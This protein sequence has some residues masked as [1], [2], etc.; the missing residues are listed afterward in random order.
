MKE[1]KKKAT[2]KKKPTRRQGAAGRQAQGSFEYTFLVT[3]TLILVA[4]GTVMVFSASWARAY[5]VE[6]QDSYYYLKRELIFASL[7]LALMF[8]MARVSYARLRQ[9]APFLMAGSLALLVL[10]FIPGMGVSAKGA[11]RWVG[12]GVASFQPSELAKLSLIIFLASVIYTRPK[13][14]NSL[15]SMAL[16]LLALPLLVCVLILLQPDMGSTII[17]VATT[18]CM[19]LVGGMKLK[20]MALLGIVTIAAGSAFAFSA[21]YRLARLTAFTDPW[22]DARES[23]FQIV[24]SLVALGSGG[25]FGVG[26]GESIQKFNYLPEA[27]TDMILSIIGEELGLVGVSGVVLAYSAFAYVGFR[28]ALRSR[29]LFGKY[30]A[31]GITSMLVSQAALNF[32]A[33]TGMLPLTGV[34]LP[35]I[36]YGGSSLVVILMSVGILLN[37]AINP[38]SQIAAPSRRKFKAIEGGDSRRRHGRSPGTGSRPRRSAQG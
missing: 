29:D 12:F 22:A 30:L 11:T 5:F 6:N 24:Q 1:A 31:A 34:P 38:R 4:I 37:I 21:P 36:S 33:V 15:R 13:L 20:H 28:I 10:V 9:L 27:H 18:A 19:L 3:V 2:G 35:M 23:G 26:I 14:L 16:P 17:I 8:A 32:C 7:G 25:P